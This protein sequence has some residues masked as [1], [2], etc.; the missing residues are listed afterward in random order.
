MNKNDI[1]PFDEIRDMN[2]S[3]GTGDNSQKH[4]LEIDIR[5]FNF[6]N[7][8]NKNSDYEESYLGEDILDQTPLSEFLKITEVQEK[9]SIP[10]Q[11]QTFTYETKKNFSET[12]FK[13]YISRDIYL[14]KERDAKL[15]L[16]SLKVNKNSNYKEKIKISDCLISFNRNLFK[17][18]EIEL[19]EKFNINLVFQ[20]SLK[21][22]DNKQVWKSLL[23]YP[24]K[25]LFMTDFSSYWKAENEAPDIPQNNLNVLLSSKDYM[26]ETLLNEPLILFIKNYL[27][28]QHQMTLFKKF[29]QKNISNPNWN[30]ENRL[31]I[32]QIVNLGYIL[33]DNK[34]SKLFEANLK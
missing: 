30:R 23:L 6:E 2:Q 18:I 19:K 28:S 29:C 9:S 34:L 16:L 8:L 20:T 4:N 7:E 5:E 31:Y 10:L 21:I 3:T 22:I 15:A 24:L 27:K 17:F 13:K 33:E 25:T 12:I 11:V 14:F 32:N 26:L 1:L